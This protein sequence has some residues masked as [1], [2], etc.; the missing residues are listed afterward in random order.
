M[1][2]RDLSLLVLNSLAQPDFMFVLMNNPLAKNLM[3]FNFNLIFPTNVWRNKMATA[4]EAKKVAAANRQAK[5]SIRKQQLSLQKKRRKPE[6][7]QLKR[8]GS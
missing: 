7:Q 3:D 4:P 6:N 1:E 8:A 5:L 2:T